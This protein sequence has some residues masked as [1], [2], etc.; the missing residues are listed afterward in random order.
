MIDVLHPIFAVRPCLSYDIPK[1]MEINETTLPEN[2]PLFFYEQILERYPDSFLLAYDREHPQNIL[3]YIMWRIERG[4]SSFGLDYVKK[5]HLVSL[6]VLPKYRRQGIASRLLRESMKVVLKYKISEFVLE[7]R[8]SNS[9]AIRLYED[10]HGYEKIR[11]ISHYYRDGEDAFYMSRRNDPINQYIPKTMGMSDEDIFRHY[12]KINQ[13]HL[14]YRCPSCHHLLIKGLN[15]S[16]SGSIHPNDTSK[17]LCA[18]CNTPISKYTISQG[19]YDIK[20]EI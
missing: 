8:V 13:H 20:M 1:V 19:T 9:G 5:A 7:V 12:Y 16:Y 3:G 17:L 2:Y 10:V 11:I 18:Y 15:Y 4:S 6:A 14:C